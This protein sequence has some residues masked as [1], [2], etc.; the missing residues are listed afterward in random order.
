MALF[1][2]FWLALS[3]GGCSLLWPPAP[4]LKP[5]TELQYDCYGWP[6]REFTKKN[7]AVAKVTR[8][9]TGDPAVD[10]TLRD[11]NGRSHRL[12]DLLADKPVLLVTGSWTCN[13]FQARQKYVSEIARDYD[14]LQV[15]LIYTIEAHPKDQPSPY[16]GK[17]WEFEF[18]DRKQATSY[19][20]RVKSAKDVDL[21][22]DVLV[23]VDGYG[24]DEMNPFWCT[25]GSC[26][27]C[28]FLVNQKG[29]LEAV[30][31]WFD[32]ASM[33]GSIDAMLER[34]GS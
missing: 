29:R 2:G 27:N 14:D 4:D 28:G 3:L 26:P 18:S 11:R 22:D 21:D 7:H 19:D 6:D 5:A 1:A 23:L 20:Q 25:Y 13:V 8:L 24:E 9:Q 12:A 30:H 33:R 10:F 17:E 31:A 15:V 34:D 16:R 32:G